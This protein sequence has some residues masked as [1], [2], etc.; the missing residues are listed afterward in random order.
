MLDQFSTSHCYCYL[1]HRLV[2]SFC[3]NCASLLLC[4]YWITI[5][6]FR[7]FYFL[8]SCWKSD[9]LLLMLPFKSLPLVLSDLILCPVS[10]TVYWGMFEPCNAATY[11]SY[12]HF[13][14][15][16]LYCCVLYSQTNVVVP[17]H[18][19]LAVAALICHKA[20]FLANW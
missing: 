13:L 16:S 7:F 6:A 5:P 8:F 15:P 11:I 12:L 1:F 14:L 10:W 20:L 17:V 18:P 19:D 9:S 4:L 2:L 3:E